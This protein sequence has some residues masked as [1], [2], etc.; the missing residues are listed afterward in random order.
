M[1]SQLEKDVPIVLVVEDH[2]EV[3]QF[4]E[5]SW[6][7]KYRVITATDG[8]AGLKAAR[9][10]VPDLVLTDIRMPEMTGTELCN[11]IKTDES[12]HI[13]VVLLTSGTGMDQELQGLESGADD[14]VTKPF[15]LE[16]LEKRIDNLIRIRQSLRE[17]YAQQTVLEAK[18]I[19]VTPTDEIFLNRVQRLLD[20]RLGDASFNAAAF[21]REVGMSRM[22][23]HRK[24]QTYTGL[25]TSAFI[26]SQRLKQ[27]AQLLRD[28]DLSVNEVAYTV[29]FNTPSYFIKCF[30]EAYGQTPAH[31]VQNTF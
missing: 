16:V 10:H 19:A 29:G 17:R 1:E 12:S 2:P 30:R 26:R 14:F 27:A 25:S 23:L 4:L 5:S 21:A 20:S 28:S 3:L 9:Q 31:Y 7:K 13:P 15:K 24:L 18:D 8:L 6:S 22:Q 11:R